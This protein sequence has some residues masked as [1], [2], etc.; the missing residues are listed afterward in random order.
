MK[1]EPLIVE[2]TYPA[3]LQQVW[4]A[5]TNPVKMNQWYFE[6]KGFKAVKGTEFS[7][8]CP[9]EDTVF[10]HLCEVTE[11]VPQQKIAYTWRYA[12]Y[13]G[14]S[15]VSWELF[16]E[17]GGTRLVLTHSGL[18]SFPQDHPS[19]VRSSFMEGWDHF[20]NK[21]LPAFLEKAAEQ[22]AQ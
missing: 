13:P 11:V 17:A 19:F 21:Q 10:R 1:K 12:D 8:D 7:F 4:D 3:T 20:V 14:N 9:H 2:R 5:I 15:E 16:P 18:E 22:V 6:M